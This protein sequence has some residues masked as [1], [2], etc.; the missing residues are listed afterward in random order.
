MKIIVLASKNPVKAQATRN[1]FQRMFPEET[2]EIHTISVPSNVKQQPMTDEET[3]QGALNRA[4]NAS[5]AIP[6]ADYWV[7]IEGGVEDSIQNEM[8]AFA[9][10]YVLSS[11]LSG[12]GRTGAFFLPQKVAQLV[13]QGEELGEADDLIFHR[14]NSK[15]ENGAIGI[16]TGDII[17]RS[18]LYEQ[19]V[20]L[21]LIPF[22]NR[23]L[24]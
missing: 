14:S 19:A 2:F 10:V 22:R 16:L 24:Y 6:E 23:D 15:Q 1:G 3:L 8:T 11:T 21:S 9:W 4:R 5:H 18:Q 17:D 7:G 13:R 12:K 20:I